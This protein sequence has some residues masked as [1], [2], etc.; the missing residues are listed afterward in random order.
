MG[1]QHEPCSRAP[2]AQAPSPNRPLPHVDNWGSQAVAF[3]V[4][5][6]G[7]VVDAQTGE[8]CGM[9]DL[10]DLSPGHQ[11]KG[12]EGGPKAVGTGGA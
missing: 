7:T 6:D 5:P 4:E 10:N 2:D 9:L 11:E 3:K 12:P 1:T 8:P